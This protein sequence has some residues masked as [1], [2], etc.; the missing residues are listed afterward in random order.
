MTLDEIK[1]IFRYQTEET[2][3]YKPTGTLNFILF[4]GRDVQP[5]TIAA[6]QIDTLAYTLTDF[7][8]EGYRDRTPLFIKPDPNLG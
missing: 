4:T 6:D 3:D 1:Q 8:H 5:K 2:P 7:T